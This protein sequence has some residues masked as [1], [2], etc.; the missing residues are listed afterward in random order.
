MEKKTPLHHHFIKSFFSDWKKRLFL[1]AIA[2]LGTSLWM[3]ME[4][5]SPSLFMASS[6]SVIPEGGSLGSKF[7]SGNFQFTDF[8]TFGLHLIK[9]AVI[10]AGGVYMIMNL[11]AGFEY[12]I[13]GISDSKERGKNALI[14]AAIGF[15]L[16]IFSWII[17]DI[18]V[19]FFQ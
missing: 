7:S 3:L 12:I 2:L 1:L 19:S 18:V 6:I 11:W 5:I 4:V 16:I 8:I 10:L 15:F 9:V 13:G 17:V 14:N